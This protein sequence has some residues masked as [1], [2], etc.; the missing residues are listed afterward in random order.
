MDNNEENGRET[1]RE[2][3]AAIDDGNFAVFHK[4]LTEN[5]NLVN[6]QVYSG[7]VVSRSLLHCT[8]NAG[9]KEMCMYLIDHG[10]NINVLDYSFM[11]PLFYLAHKGEL[12]LVKEFISKGAWVDGESRGVSTPLIY[13]SME[14]HFEVVD[15]L[16]KCGADMNRLHQNMNRTALEIATAYR[17]E[18]VSELLKLNGALKA[19]EE[20]DLSTERAAGVLWEIHHDAGWVLSSKFSKDSIDVRTALLKE[21]KKHK[22]LFT[23]G[24]FQQIPRGELMMCVPYD[25]PANKQLLQE[26]NHASFPMQL[27]LA[28]AEHRLAGNDMYDG[29]F[30]EKQDEKWNHLAWPENID[31]FIVVNYQFGNEP[32]PEKTD[33]TVTLFLLVP[34]KY[35]KSGR[36]K[37]KKLAERLEKKRCAK[38]ARNALK[39]DYINDE[40]TYPVWPIK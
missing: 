18:K 11:T 16:I 27:L 30:V 21:D 3:N 15:Y 38:W 33:E 26:N 4:L 35:P 6:M 40:N 23:I 24:M 5:P 22:L 28:L 17:Q 20:F 14:G 34:I 10:I 36:P 9:N 13:A 37:A 1:L 32:E 7:T 19:H 12:A 8:A 29:Y 31:A 25:W 39:Y 2:V